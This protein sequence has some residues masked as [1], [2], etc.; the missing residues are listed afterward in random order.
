MSNRR[1]VVT[2]L[3]VVSPVGSTVEKAWDNIKAGNSGINAISP[4]L[5]DAENFS[6]RI[7]GNVKDF[8]ATAYIKPKDQKKMDPF[9]HYGIGAGTDALQDLSLI[10]I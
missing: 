9:I 2:G 8:D 10:H 1:V 7:A 5:F 3:G 6:V 4:E